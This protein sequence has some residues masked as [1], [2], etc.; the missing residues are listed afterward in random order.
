MMLKYS[1]M[2]FATAQRLVWHNRDKAKLSWHSLLPC[3]KWDA[4]HVC[5]GEDLQCER[6]QRNATF[7]HG[8]N[9]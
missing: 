1:T 9:F 2:K 6:E 3:Y 5:I 8:E 4:L 7:P